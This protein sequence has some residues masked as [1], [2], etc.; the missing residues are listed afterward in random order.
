MAEPLKR[1]LGPEVAQRLA[2]EVA[3]VCPAFDRTA[4]LA[5]ALAGCEN[6]ELMAR[7]RHWAR[8]LQRHLPPN[9]EAAMQVLLDSVLAAEGAR[10]PGHV[11]AHPSGAMAPFF[12]LPHT[13]F[14][15]EFGLGHFEASMRAQ[16]FLTQRFTAEYSIRPFLLHHTAATLERLAQWATDPNPHVRRLVSE[17]TR[18]RLP[19]GQRLRAFQQD[20]AP[21]LALLERLK[22]D[23]EL[24][25]RRSV[26]NHLN[27]IGKDHP[28]L[29]VHTAR[30]WW[31]GASAQRQW[32]VR[33]ALRF[34]VKKG[35]PGALAVLGF[36][37]VARVDIAHARVQPAVVP[38]GGAV[39][40]AFEL[41][42]SHAHAQ[43]LL[44]D[45]CVYWVKARGA[46][47]PKVFKLKTTTLAPGA[48]VAM[49]KRLSLV[50]LSTRTLYPGLHR[51]DV[52]I[53]GVAHP[54]GAFELIEG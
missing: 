20:P 52:L 5:D 15:A 53:N 27:D 40:L 44:V 42:N 30:R 32:V 14:V 37:E 12:Y 41:H 45:F 35:H 11:P 51:V 16:H 13:C 29:L 22:D 3:V 43:H 18:P 23:P 50:P 25:V 1:Q 4:F 39:E 8:A 9:P 46:A 54:L 48:R 38:M 33:H 36:G 7:G 21:V 6:L 26:A 10:P 17:G 2:H 47:S 19:W 24:Y 28:E 31:A 34:A 49:A